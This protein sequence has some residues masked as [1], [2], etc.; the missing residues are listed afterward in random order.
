MNSNR[1]PRSS[2]QLVDSIMRLFQIDVDTPAGDIGTV[3][4]QEQVSQLTDLVSA[5]SRHIVILST[6]IR[7]LQNASVK[8]TFT[9]EDMS[10]FIRSTSDKPDTTTTLNRNAKEFSL[11]SSSKFS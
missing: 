6:K 10:Q 5:L 8:P 9:S 3:S 11:D 2:E 4:L 7:E 1:D